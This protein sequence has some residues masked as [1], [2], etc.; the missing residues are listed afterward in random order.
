M[1]SHL[2]AI[3]LL[4]S[5]YT[6]GAAELSSRVEPTSQL[7]GTVFDINEARVSN[8]RVTIEGMGIKLTVTTDQAGQYNID[9]PYGTYALEIDQSGFCRHKRPP[10]RVSSPKVVLNFTLQVCGI[11]LTVT[12]DE[13]VC[14]PVDP[15]NTELV[16]MSNAG[17]PGLNAHVRYA[18]RQQMGNVVE[19][20]GRTAQRT[21]DGRAH[22]PYGLTLEYSLLTIRADVLRL[23]KET[24][25]IEAEGNILVEDGKSSIHA[26]RIV[27]DISGDEPRVDV[28]R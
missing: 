6:C 2:L 4:V 24:R 26:T 10:F 27:A 9:I 14:V 19:Y 13:T 20:R 22:P 15:F 12:A 1:K 5:T 23:N 8:A 11:A 18:S 28:I 16:P 25:R 17:G 3:T 21:P 7:S